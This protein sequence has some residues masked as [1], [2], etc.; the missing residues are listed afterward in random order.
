[1]ITMSGFGGGPPPGRE[2]AQAIDDVGIV[3]VE[4][5]QNVIFQ[6]HVAQEVDG[7]LELGLRNRLVPGLRPRPLLVMVE[8]PD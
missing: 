1:M 5:G 6:H 4:L 7:G 2:G 8:L 3:D